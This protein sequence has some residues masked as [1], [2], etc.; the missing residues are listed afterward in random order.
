MQDVLESNVDFPHAAS[1]DGCPFA[2]GCGDIDPLQRADTDPPRVIVAM[3]DSIHL[4]MRWLGFIPG[5]SATGMCGTAPWGTC[6]P[7][8][9]LRLREHDSLTPL[10]L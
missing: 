3:H 9:T 10:W 4:E 8:V 2:P 1:V 7:S 5:V 6:T